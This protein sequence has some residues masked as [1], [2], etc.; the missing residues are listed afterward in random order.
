MN[1]DAVVIGSNGSIGAS[2][3]DELLANQFDVVGITKSGADKFDRPFKVLKTNALDVNEVV[4]AT[5]TAKYIFGAFNASEYSNKAW[6]Q[7][8][9]LFM[10]SFIE[11]GKNSGARLIF[12]DNLYTYLD[13][14]GSNSY[15]EETVVKPKSAKGRIRNKIAKRFLKAISEKE[16]K[17]CI[18]RGSDIYGP[19]GMTS[20]IG[21]RFF[22]KMIKTGVAEL[23]PLGNKRHSFTFTRDFA[24]LALIA[25]Q[26][27]HDFPILHVP[28]AEAIGYED[29][30]V[31]VLNTYSRQDVRIRE[32]PKLFF[33]ILGVFSP[34]IRS[35]I[36]ESF[37]FKNEYIA[38]SVLV[39]KLVP[40]FHPTSIVEGLKE[41]VE[42]FRKLYEYKG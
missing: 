16:I 13:L 1:T 6:S 2:I 11:A 14:K 20:F 30:V 38:E 22:E 21:A 27:D 41:T 31:R 15:T 26:Q 7:E 33:N 24:K 29:L 18:V 34:G 37:H 3:V 36:Q 39:S 19:Y 10:E 4:N 5:K 42:W 9:P 8:F 17:G 23:L 12:I 40:D 28:N 32:I 25:A 35:V